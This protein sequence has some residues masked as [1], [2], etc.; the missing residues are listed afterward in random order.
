MRF[1]VQR[2]SFLQHEGKNGTLKAVKKLECIQKDPISVVH[3]NHHLVLHNRVLDYKPFYL[4][5]LLYNDRL[6]FEYW[7]NAK[8]IIPMDDFHYFRYRMQN[9]SQFHSPFFERIK[10]RR[11]ELKDCVSLVLTEIRKHG[12]LS[13]K[14]LET[15]GKLKRRSATRVLNL[16][17]DSGD[18]MIHH[19][20]GNR[21]YY[22]LTEL[23]LPANV[24]SRTMSREEYAQFMVEKYMRACGLVD[25]RDWRFG[26]LSLNASQRKTTV[27]EMVKEQKLIQIKVKGLNQVYYVLKEYIELLESSDEPV[28]ESVFFVAPLDN[29]LWNRRLIAEVFNFN[30]AWEV[31]KTPEKRMYGYYVMPILFGSRFVGRLDPKLER[32]NREMIINSVH[33]EEK[34]LERDIFT[35]EFAKAFQR[36]LEFHD[37]SQFNIQKTEPKRLRNLL[38][39]ESD[40]VTRR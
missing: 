28:R 24:D 7:C 19:M 14:E 31:Y 11:E 39:K 8:S 5:D 32:R 35:S 3:R 15:N 30:Y 6:L 2:Q 17:W 21:R 1:L 40:S 22:G 38:M 18:L 13:S 26:W 9:P 4:D 25:T 36:F 27:K 20:E 16:L 34:N 33:L 37:V 23:L 12:P 10:R 29:L